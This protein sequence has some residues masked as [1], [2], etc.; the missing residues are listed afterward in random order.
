MEKSGWKRLA[1]V[2]LVLIL[3]FIGLMIIGTYAIEKE[4]RMQNECYYDICSTNEEAY[5]LEEVCYCYDYDLMGELQVTDQR[6]LG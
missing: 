3:V 5:L 2:E 6:Y 1:L 4:E